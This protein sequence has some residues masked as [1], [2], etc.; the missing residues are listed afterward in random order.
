MDTEAQAAPASDAASDDVHADVRAAF[1]ALSTKAETATDVAPIERTRDESGKF[2]QAAQPDTVTDVDPNE[3]KTQTSSPTH[4][5]P[6]SWSADAKA[7]W[8]TLDSSIQA[9]IARREQNMDEGG[10]KWS[11]E[12]RRYEETIAP[13]REAARK[14]GIDET[15]GIKR[16]LAAQDFLDRDPLSAIAWLAQAY[17]VDL[18]NMNATQPARPQADPML[19]QLSQKVSALQSNI[20]QRETRE[21][22]SQI[23][24]F[25]SAQGHDHFED[26][27]ETM[28]KLLI[29]GLA[30]DMEEAYQMAVWQTPSI[31]EKLMAAQTANQQS[32]ADKAKQQAER[33]KKAA[34]SLSGSPAHGASP[35][36]KQD[37]DSVEDAARAAARAHGWSV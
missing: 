20:E 2:T 23:E 5:P 28:G 10:R 17:G 29:N 25:K 21:L 16:L 24:A 1:E 13:V 36:P 11:E 14:N 33:A 34:I 35:V 12:K 7:K 37:Y 19:T 27:K 6:T 8:A 22:Q 30:G 26:V 9:E 15:E 3:G 18:Q 32:A 31:R 4:E